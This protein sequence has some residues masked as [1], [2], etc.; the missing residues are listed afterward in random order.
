LLG[1]RS[2]SAVGLFVVPVVVDSI[3]RMSRR[4][5]LPHVSK[6]VFERIQPSIAYDD[7]TPT[8]MGVRMVSNVV[9]T[10][11]HCIP[12]IEFD[13]MAFPM[14]RIASD[15]GLNFKAPT[16]SCESPNDAFNVDRLSVATVARKVP[17]IPISTRIP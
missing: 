14:Y 8:V 10:A 5:A 17:K 15:T 6:K 16:T 11:F 12:C 1:V 2:P 9:A 13:S 4:W 7:S 3:N